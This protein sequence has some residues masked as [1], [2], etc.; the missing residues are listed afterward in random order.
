MG[1]TQHRIGQY[2]IRSYH[3][4]HNVYEVHVHIHTVLVRSG[5]VTLTLGVVHVRVPLSTVLVDK[6]FNDMVVRQGM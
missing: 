3:S 2:T 5:I 4:P 1:T 6:L